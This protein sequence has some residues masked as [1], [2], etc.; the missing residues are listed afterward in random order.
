MKKMFSSFERKCTVT[1][2]QIKTA[3]GLT[4]EE[5]MELVEALEEEIQVRNYETVCLKI[6][7]E[8]VEQ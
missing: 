2:E 1:K 4:E 8:E 7:V 3:L 6:T 5:F